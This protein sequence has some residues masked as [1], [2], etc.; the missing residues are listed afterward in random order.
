MGTLRW[1]EPGALD[2]HIWR[3]GQLRLAAKQ[4]ID[5]K[6]AYKTYVV[7]TVALG[8]IP[9]GW[10]TEAV[11][12]AP[13]QLFFV[14][15][16][17]IAKALVA[18]AQSTEALALLN[19]EIALL[20]DAD[21]VGVL[22]AVDAYYA[23]SAPRS[24]AVQYA[25]TTRRFLLRPVSVISN[26]TLL[27]DIEYRTA[28][29]RPSPK[30]NDTLSDRVHPSLPDPALARPAGALEFT[31]LG[32]LAKKQLAHFTGRIEI[33][34][35]SCVNLLDAHDAI[36]T[37]IK[38]TRKSG[39]PDEL[40]HPK[41]RTALTSGNAYKRHKPKKIPE[42]AQFPLAVRMLDK[43]E[44][45]K[46]ND[47]VKIE[48]QSI[49]QLSPLAPHGTF[50][51]RFSIL[52]SEFYASRL[53]VTACF[54]II[55]LSTGWNKSTVISLNRERVQKIPGG[56]KLSGL[57]ARSGQNESESIG[58]H[59]ETDSQ[60]LT[61]NS[62]VIGL[63]GKL[64]NTAENEDCEVLD[65]PAV[66][67]IE[68]LL[69][70]RDN[71]D[72]Y[73]I[74]EEKSLFVTLALDRLR[75]RH[76]RVKLSHDEINE[77]CDFINHPRFRADDLRKQFHSQYHLA[78]KQDI[79]IS[80]AKLNHASPKTSMRYVDGTALRMSHEAIIKD[81]GEI[82]S[83]ALEYSA[84]RIIFNG[85]DSDRKSKLI[86]NLLL[87]PS[88]PQHPEDGESIADKW[89]ASSGSVAFEVGVQE[90]KHCVY[91]RKYYQKNSAKLISAN[92]QR[93]ERYHLPRI[94]FCEALYRVILSSPL[95]G[96]L[97]SFEAGV[98]K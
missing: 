91:Q 1:T 73:G 95:G 85:G 54:V 69:R 3:D 74:S 62:Q 94:L 13:S 42:A 45:Q 38:A 39:V 82:L 88:S 41:T 49:T 92:E 48:L 87:F 50:E 27:C 96:Q 28:L 7:D 76:F 5:G 89:V 16:A 61:S 93:F 14:Q 36:I 46:P 51:E 12:A 33:L 2:R 60:Q 79:R 23:T 56:Y 64:I 52:L 78:N 31:D 26:G 72:E 29:S 43:Y 70:H 35:A 83:S 75:S 15:A 25:Q 90:I 44:L 84:G 58:K 59:I 19:V 97:R 17:P 21:V 37:C 22:A 9:G 80:Q 10:L 57:K 6:T 65:T 20:L 4:T 30:V 98:E 11:D 66:R 55:M 68:I 32:D 63:V 77:F 67:A 53:V 40:L 81:Y 86:K 24:V 18:L 34:I 47:R 71:V 8:L